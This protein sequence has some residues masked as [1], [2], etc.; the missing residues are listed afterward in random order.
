MAKNKSGRGGRSGG[1]VT[2]L[3][4]VKRSGKRR[5]RSIPSA[6]AGFRFLTQGN[7]TL[8][9]PD[10]KHHWTDSERMFRSLIFDRDGRVVS[11]GLPKFFDWQA[12][13][14]LAAEA[15][16][17][18]DA[19]Q[20]QATVKH[21]GALVI[22]SVIR[23]QVRWR[24]R[25]GFDVGQF[26]GRLDTFLGEHPQLVDPQFAAS[27]SLCFEW[28]SPSDRVVLSYPSDRLILIGAVSHD[29][30]ELLSLDELAPLS[31]QAGIDLTETLADLPDTLTELQALVDDWEG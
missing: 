26:S 22:R 14:G 4:L 21:D 27:L 19:G 9:L 25:N 12:D 20:L 11:C 5:G 28:V 6:S 29:T 2:E 15:Q 24:T 8:V 18:L 7:L 13:S 10:S 30:L 31:E 17:A 23:G 3:S 1:R 16:M